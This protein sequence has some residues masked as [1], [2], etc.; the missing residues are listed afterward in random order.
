MEEKRKKEI[1]KKIGNR[2]YKLRKSKKMSRENFAEL[3]DISAQHVYYIEKGD[4]LPG[5]ITLIDI[6]NNFSI[7]PSQILMDSLDINENIFNEAMQND[8]SKL[9]KEDKLFIQELV[10]NTIKLLINKK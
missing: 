10:S 7:T 1:S 4:F 3:C 5:C 6:C 9:S 2:I 8:F